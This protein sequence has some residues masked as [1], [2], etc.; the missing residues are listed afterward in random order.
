MKILP[1]LMIVASL[2][3]TASCVVAPYGYYDDYPYHRVY[4]Y[5]PYPDDYYHYYYPYYPDRDYHRDGEHQ[6]HRERR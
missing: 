3:A 1:V 2:L 4:H 6:E 5:Y